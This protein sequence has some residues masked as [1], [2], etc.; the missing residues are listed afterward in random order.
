MLTNNNLMICWSF[1][2]WN[3]FL[4]RIFP[5][6]I[7]TTYEQQLQTLGLGIYLDL[8][9]T[10]N[11]NTQIVLPDGSSLVSQ[12]ITLSHYKLLT[13]Q[14]GTSRVRSFFRVSNLLATHGR[15]LYKTQNL[16][17]LVDLVHHPPHPQRFPQ[18]ICLN[19]IKLMVLILW[20]TGVRSDCVP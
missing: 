1:K 18:P 17:E 11:Q 7:Y 8:S 6:V 20:L 5:P 12:D 10:K 16:K 2:T 9:L 15:P 19:T 14:G 3:L 13:E 4:Q